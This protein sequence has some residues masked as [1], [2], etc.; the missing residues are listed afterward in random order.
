[1]SI[2][3]TERDASAPSVYVGT[4]AK[5]NSGSIQGA[6]LNLE[7]Y[8][9]EES[10]LEACHELHADE[11]DPEFMFQDFENFP[12][13]Y[14]GESGLSADLWDW[15]ELDSDDREKLAAFIECFGQVDNA[16]EKMEDAYLGEYDSDEAQAWDYIE[17][18]GMFEGIPESITNY[19]DI[20]K[21]ARDC[22]HDVISHNNHY[23]NRNW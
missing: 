5:Y 19:F 10:F 17:S 16:I 23:F 15:L 7:H 13:E 12:R 9:D 6:W 2:E 3:Q 1:M 14:Y 20:E 8:S 22:S 4:Y 21:F 11:S 18:T